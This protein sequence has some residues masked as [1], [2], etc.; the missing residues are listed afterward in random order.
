MDSFLNLRFVIMLLLVQQKGNAIAV[1]VR[2]SQGGAHKIVG[3]V[4]VGF[5][6]IGKTHQPAP[7]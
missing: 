6:D 5:V 7:Q 4:R 3:Y 2:L 1:V